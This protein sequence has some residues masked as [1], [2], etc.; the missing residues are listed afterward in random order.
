MGIL[1]ILGFVLYFVSLFTGNPVSQFIA[2]HEIQH[3]AAITYPTLD[4]ELSKI[5]YNFKNSAYGCHAQSKKAR[6]QNF[7]S[8]IAA[9]ESVTTINMKVAN[10]F[11]T[12]R[13]ISK[14]F[15]HI[16][17]DIIEK[18]YSHKTTLII[19]DLI[20]DTQQ[21]TPDLPLNLNNIPLQLSLTV[22]ILSD[23]RN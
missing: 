13:R 16:V 9:V 21:L 2:S 12:Y 18:E 23:V 22:N 17:A 10:H 14:D 7:I 20:G 8:G 4:L 19:G 5:K 6:I 15:N 3:Y 1:L 11:T